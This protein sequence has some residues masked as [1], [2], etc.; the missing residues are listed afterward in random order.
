[1]TARATVVIPNW[2]GKRLLAL[3]LKS[4][5]NQTFQDFET[6]VVDND[7]TD[8]SIGFLGREFPEVN[9]ISLGDNMGFAAAV[10]SS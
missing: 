3:C 8:G 4:L 10:N 7:S 9:V 6:I 1:M 5:R 2:N